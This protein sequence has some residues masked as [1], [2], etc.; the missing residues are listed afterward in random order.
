MPAAVELRAEDVEE[1][2]RRF[3]NASR[4][5][6]VRSMAIQC[7][8]HAE[9]LRARCSA[10]DGAAESLQVIETI[11]GV[12]QDLIELIEV[13]NVEEELVEA[14]QEPARGEIFEV[15]RHQRAAEAQPFQRG[16]SF[17]RQ[18]GRRPPLDRGLHR[19]R[20][21]SESRNPQ[22]L[23]AC[24]EGRRLEPE[25]MKVQGTQRG[26]VGALEADGEVGDEHFESRG[27][28]GPLKRARRK[29]GTR[30]SELEHGRWK[31]REHML[32]AARAISDS[33]GPLDGPEEPK[34]GVR[35]AALERWPPHATGSPDE[36][37]APVCSGDVV[38]Q[39]RGNACSV[40]LDGGRKRVACV[41][42]AFQLEPNQ[43]AERVPRLKQEISEHLIRESWSGDS[44]TACHA[45]SSAD[46][47][48][49]S[50]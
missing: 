43:L 14:A 47:I 50:R 39:L 17:T 11:R 13:L 36:P 20:Q 37:S 25:R 16:A 19:H 44:C 9:R 38:T 45:S 49:S 35:E 12:A 42:F 7:G 6:R 48:S 40:S 27:G 30:H 33:E 34:R 2:E 41:S 15:L 18:E 32:D 23:E 8:V 10:G 21:L 28:S 26:R 31:C 5:P 22:R 3:V 4:V 24:N 29:V 1:A 46:D